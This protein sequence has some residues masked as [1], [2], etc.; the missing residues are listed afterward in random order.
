MPKNWSKKERKTL[1]EDVGKLHEK[2]LKKP[3]RK[4]VPIKSIWIRTSDTFRFV[5]SEY[6][7]KKLFFLYAFG[8]MA[9]LFNRAIALNWGNELGFYKILVL[10]IIASP[11]LGLLLFNFISGVLYFIGMWLKGS[12]H[13]FEIRTVVGYSLIPVIS[14]IFIYF[15]KVAIF[16]KDIFLYDFY[17]LETTHLWSNVFLIFRAFEIMLGIIT[18]EILVTGISVIQRFPSWKAFINIFLSVILVIAIILVGTL[19][20]WLMR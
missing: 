10:G 6:D 3:K 8:G 12:A 15:I 16:G 2:A 9:I 14:V 4:I 13:F 17:A 20:L 1:Q 19:F 5:V 11:V 18:I 7:R